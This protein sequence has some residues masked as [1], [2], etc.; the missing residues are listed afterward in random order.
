MF[1]AEQQALLRDSGVPC[2][3]EP[4]LDVDFGRPFVYDPKWG[5]F[6][7]PAGGHPR[8]MAA[9]ACLH[10]G[11]PDILSAEQHLG[12]QDCWC[13]LADYWLEHYHGCYRSSV[14][15]EITV[16]DR[17]SLEEWEVRVIEA[18]HRKISPHRGWW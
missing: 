5:V 1:T 18:A 16:W 7:V 15:E 11:F 9:L 6:Y 10:L 3:P 2:N 13:G 12:L 14:S 8:A 17:D 4:F